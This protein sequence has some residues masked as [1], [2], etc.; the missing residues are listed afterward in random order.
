MG[1][2]SVLDN[3]SLK[4]KDT[5]PADSGTYVADAS[6]GAGTNKLSYNV[7]VLGKWK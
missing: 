7:G 3:G 2:A 5:L 4:I 6:N 1:R